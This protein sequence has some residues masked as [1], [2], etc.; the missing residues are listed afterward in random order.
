MEKRSSVNESP[1][2]M[3]NHTLFFLFSIQQ[4]KAPRDGWAKKIGVE[5]SRGGEYGNRKQ[6]INALIE[7]CL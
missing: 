3:T 6:E 1:L 7:R 2:K 5:Y 4:L